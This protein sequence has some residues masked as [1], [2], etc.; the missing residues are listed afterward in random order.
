ML[1]IKAVTAIGG[2]RLR[3]TLT[4][5]RVVERDVS[6]LMWGPVF[7]RIAASDEAFAEVTVANGTASWLK[8]GADI[9]PETLIWNGP[10]P[11]D[12]SGSVPAAKLKV[13]S[14]S[15]PRP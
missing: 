3:L 1:E 4:D 14:L 13:V 8:D 12:G 2:R 6:D 11:A 15:R 5:D 9:A 7:E 10:E